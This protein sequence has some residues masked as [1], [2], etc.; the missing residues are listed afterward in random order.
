MPDFHPSTIAISLCMMYPKWYKGKLRSIKHT[1][2]IRGDLALATAKKAQELGY[3]VVVVERKS[4]HTFKKELATIKGI[5]VSH[6]ISDKFSAGKRKSLKLAADIPGV[7]VIVMTEPEKLS[8]V[9]HCV[10]QLVQPIFTNSADIVMPKRDLKLFEQTYPKYMFES[11]IEGNGLYSELLRTHH[12][13][14]SSMED[15]DIFFGPRVIKN[16][17]KVVSLFLKKYPV[18]IHRKPFAVQY[19]DVEHYSNSLYFPVVVALQKGFRVTIVTIPFRYPREQKENEEKGE[20]S[21]FV[22]KRKA[23]KLGLLVELF[24]FLMFLEERKKQ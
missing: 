17:P 3:T 20:R 21:L 6:I 9:A 12:L 16:D 22:E 13:L 8:L 5:R 19:F 10:P 2:K 7:L 4:S 11:E 23:Q 24:H 18:K 14:P 1:D 15:L